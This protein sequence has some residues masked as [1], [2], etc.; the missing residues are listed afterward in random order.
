MGGISCSG[1]N[2]G[3][4]EMQKFEFKIAEHDAMKNGM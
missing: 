3:W 2:I 4:Q 1:G